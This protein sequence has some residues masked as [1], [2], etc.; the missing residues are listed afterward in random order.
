[1]PRSTQY[2]FHKHPD[3]DAR[4]RS[5]HNLVHLLHSS[6]D[7][8]IEHKREFLKLAL[9]KVTEA[10]ANNK[11]RTRYCSESAFANPSEKL[12]HDHVFQRAIMVD[13]LLSASVKEIPAIL[14]EAVG[15]TITE[16]EH[17]S[18][19]AFKHLDGWE[20]YERAGIR[21]RDCGRVA[22]I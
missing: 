18:L 10:E 21:T 19:N 14:A 12:R 6:K 3:A 4:L 17:R 7:L 20:R 15:C 22:H 16:E 2:S 1:M 8:T 11:H 9:W 13:R 5:A